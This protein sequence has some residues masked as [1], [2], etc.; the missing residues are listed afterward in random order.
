MLFALIYSKI[1]NLKIPDY[2]LIFPDIVDTPKSF[3]P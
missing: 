3:N 2:K 1:L